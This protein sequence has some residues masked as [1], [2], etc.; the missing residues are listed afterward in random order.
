MAGHRRM[1]RWLAAAHAMLGPASGLRA[2]CDVGAAPLFACLGYRLR[3]V[4]AVGSDLS[5]LTAMLVGTLEGSHG[6]TL[7][8][9]IVPW[10]TRLDQTWRTAIGAALVTMPDG[11]TT[12]GLAHGRVGRDGAAD[13]GESRAGRSVSTD[14]GCVSWMSIGRMRGGFSSSICARR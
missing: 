9:V 10:Q 5:S 7:R 6:V 2:L 14:G 8:I 13:G 12:G 11:R 3:D 4:T 1:R